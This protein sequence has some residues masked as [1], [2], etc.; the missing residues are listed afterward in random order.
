MTLVTSSRKPVPEVRSLGKEIAFALGSRFISRGKQGI[1]DL[2]VTD[3]TVL[4]ICR[5]LDGYRFRVTHEG[6]VI[7]DYHIPTFSITPR[8]GSIVKGLQVSNRSV[9]DELKPYLAVQYTGKEN[10]TI[11]FDGT[12]KKRYTLEV[13]G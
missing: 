8:S 5:Q 10:C 13:L 1:E 4:F 6:A 12:Q 7:A 2:R 9:F 3:P 11:T